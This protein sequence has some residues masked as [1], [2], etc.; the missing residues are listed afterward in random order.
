MPKSSQKAAG[1]NES[2]SQRG[3]SRFGTSGRQARVVLPERPPRMVDNEIVSILLGA[4]PATL[5]AQAEELKSVTPA[6]SASSA[7]TLTV[8][9]APAPSD[10]RPTQVL[11]AAEPTPV[12][13]IEATAGSAQGG[14]VEHTIVEGRRVTSDS[15][16]PAESVT[17]L[18]LT[19]QPEVAAPSPTRA[20]RDPSVPTARRA[21]E[22]SAP[23]VQGVVSRDGTISSFEEFAERWKHGLRKGQ[24][25]ICEVLYQKTYAVGQTECVTSFS[26]LGRLSGLKM[27][28][29]FNIIAQLEALRFVER[30]RSEATSNKK[31][32]GS[33]IRFHLYPVQ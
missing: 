9:E 33:V 14:S 7:P 16:V 24:L 12:G 20:R 22:G 27:R 4:D 1:A 18:P 10:A 13:D 15:R 8:V 3:K 32:Q 11:T 25:K 19:V 31:D 2:A 5:T 23:A 28:Q 29:C 17:T 21:D 26:E 30:S 6:E